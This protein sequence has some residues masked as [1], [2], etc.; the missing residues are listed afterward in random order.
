MLEKINKKFEETGCDAIHGNLLY[1]DE[2]TMTHPQ[3]KWITKSTNIRTGNI[4]AHPTLYVSKEAYKK[5][6]LYNL[7]YKIAADYDF[8]V[9]LL[10]NKDIKLEYINEYLIY[11]RHGG[12]SSD[13]LKGYKKSLKDSYNVLKDNHIKFPAFISLLRIIKTLWQ[14]VTAK[15]VKIEERK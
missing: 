1:M 14:M 13:G 11:M 3:R 12:T 2:E 10:T 5:L 9:R 6:G 4:T 15:F 8:M 7:K